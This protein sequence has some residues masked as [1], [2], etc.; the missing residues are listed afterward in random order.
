MA[1]HKYIIQSS[2]KTTLLLRCRRFY[3]ISKYHNVVEIVRLFYMQHLNTGRYFSYTSI[4]AKLGDVQS[5]SNTQLELSE[6][7][8]HA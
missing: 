3:N 5:R 4:F 6:E 1:V 2:L 8:M 7:A